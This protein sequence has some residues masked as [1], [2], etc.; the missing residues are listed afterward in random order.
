MKQ[1]VVKI[2]GTQGDVNVKLLLGTVSAATLGGIVHWLRDPRGGHSVL[3]FLI[4][5]ATA[6]FVGMQAHFI[7]RYL[8][9]AEELQF[10]VAGA[11]GYGGG[12]LLDAAV[13]MII[14]WG[15]KR[16]G[17]EYIDPQRRASD[18]GA[19]NEE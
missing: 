7:M 5:V 15:Y 12:A 13:P 6:A 16:I 14:K 9:F 18:A 8:G 4:S 19:S 2:D 1:G 17:V 11:C 3:A 10:A